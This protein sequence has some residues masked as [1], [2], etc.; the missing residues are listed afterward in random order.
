MEAGCLLFGTKMAIIST[1]RPIIAGADFFRLFYL[2]AI[3]YEVLGAFIL[4]AAGRGYPGQRPNDYFT[5]CQKA[6]GSTRC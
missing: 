5:L 4:T 2:V 1:P 3:P 6:V